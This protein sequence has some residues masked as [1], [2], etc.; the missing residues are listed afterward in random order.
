VT[1]HL[2][3]Y[4]T[5]TGSGDLLAVAYC[6]ASEAYRPPREDRPVLMALGVD[7]L[8]RHGMTGE[9]DCAACLAASP[10]RVR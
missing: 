3:A 6:G 8:P 10:R 2:H 5:R 1:R 7:G 4:T 9:A